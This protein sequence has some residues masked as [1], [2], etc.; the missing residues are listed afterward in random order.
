MAYYT[1]EALPPAAP[2][3]VYSYQSARSSSPRI[4]YPPED[5]AQA[6]AAAF[7]QNKT[8]VVSRP[9]FSSVPPN[10]SQ[11][12][13][14]TVQVYPPDSLSTS[15]SNGQS[16]TGALPQQSH[17]QDPSRL[18]PS[19]QILPRRKPLDDRNN[20]N[21][22]SH[23][24]IASEN[25]RY[26]A[27]EL[28]SSNKPARHVSVSFESE[29]TENFEPLRYHHQALED[30]EM[31]ALDTRASKLTIGTM[32][33]DGS[34]GSEPT[35]QDLNVA[36]RSVFG[37]T[38]QRPDSGFSSTSDLRGRAQGRSHSPH[39]S[40]G[41]PSSRHSRSPD[42]RPLSYV[43]LLNV[44]Y[45]QNAPSGAENLVNSGLRNVVGTKPH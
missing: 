21:D 15:Q 12:M 45:P 26:T 40:A 20:N 3:P 23:R 39:L 4:S 28:N 6:N 43:D 35:K 36:R 2:P 33:S 10:V 5:I 14:S 8:I 42:A 44:P 1:E 25:L 41:R 19:P 22:M 37:N 31:T 32:Q 18:S 27:E 24:R 16:Y 13:G 38:L 30:A 17:Y 11:D 34:A 29:Q 9:T 7:Q